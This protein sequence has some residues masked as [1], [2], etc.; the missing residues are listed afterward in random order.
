[1]EGR[2]VV[3]QKPGL[4]HQDPGDE[5]LSLPVQLPLSH[6]AC[7][8]PL[9]S[10]SDTCQKSQHRPRLQ[11]TLTLVRFPKDP[12]TK[13]TGF[14]HILEKGLSSSDPCAPD[15]ELG[16]EKP[17]TSTE[18][19]LTSPQPL[20]EPF[21][22]GRGS[23]PLTEGS[24]VLFSGRLFTPRR[25]CGYLSPTTPNPLVGSSSA[26]SSGPTGPSQRSATWTP[27]SSS[28]LLSPSLCPF[29]SATSFTATPA[30]RPAPP[31]LPS[32]T[33]AVLSATSSAAGSAL[34]G[35]GDAGGST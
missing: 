24:P 30:R 27:L 7:L 6:V 18:R 17:S 31:P 28:S 35:G 26:R 22:P 5:P 12:K 29:V 32:S 23:L 9:S 19:F 21:V 25:P 3:S 34:D 11:M 4:A 2:G 16:P 10:P 14:G 13:N 15:P 8:L 1:M 33:P 20:K